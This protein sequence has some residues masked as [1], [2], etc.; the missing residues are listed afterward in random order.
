MTASMIGG[1]RTG[2][3][4]CKDS[5]DHRGATVFQAHAAPQET[6]ENLI[7]ALKILT[8]QQKDGDSQVGTIVTGLLEK[9]R[10]KIVDGRREVHFR[11]QSRSCER[12][13]HALGN[14][15][16]ES[17]KDKVHGPGSCFRARCA[18]HLRYIECGRPNVEA[19]ASRRRLARS[20]PGHF[21]RNRRVRKGS[22]MI[23]VQGFAPGSEKQEV[24]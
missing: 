13:R 4:S 16:E 8:N 5:T 14:K 3:W 6:C 10:S 7:N 19:P 1:L 2:Y 15:V 21:P 9:S 22:H 11:R 18:A 23:S 24:K 12:R 17:G 20:L